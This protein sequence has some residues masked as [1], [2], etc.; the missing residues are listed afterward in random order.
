MT[1]QTFKFIIQ[2]NIF[3]NQINLFVYRKGENIFMN[4]IEAI[5]QRANVQQIREFLLNGAET[6]EVNK[7]PYDERL[8]QGLDNAIKML[9]TYLPDNS[10]KMENEIMEATTVYAEVYMEIGLQA[11]IMLAMQFFNPKI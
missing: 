8:I 7:E 10:E 5:F 6:C 9:H 1:T 4:Y 3:D 2:I 11:G